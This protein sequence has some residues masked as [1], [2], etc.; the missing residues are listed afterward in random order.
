[1]CGISRGDPPL[2]ISWLKDGSPVSAK[3]G[4]NISAL[5]PY[6]SLLSISSLTASHSGEYT[7]VAVNP[8]AQVR[9][10]SKLQVKGN[11]LNTRHQ[12]FRAQYVCLSFQRFWHIHPQN[13]KLL[14]WNPSFLSRGNCCTFLFYFTRTHVLS[15]FTSFSVLCIYLRPR[16]RSTSRRSSVP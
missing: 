12:Q 10:S 7:C 9:Y 6:S 15:Y 14:K 16:I 5:D 3:F 8:A 1:M 4:V 11:S 2:E 13:S